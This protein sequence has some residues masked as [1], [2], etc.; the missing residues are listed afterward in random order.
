MAGDKSL[1]CYGNKGR[2]LCTSLEEDT[3]PSV[4]GILADTTPNLSGA[5]L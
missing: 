5:F 1:G 4:D 2:T 3:L